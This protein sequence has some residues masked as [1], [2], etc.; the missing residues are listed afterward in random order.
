MAIVGNLY[1]LEK[2]FENVRL[3]PVFDYLK[4]ATDMSSSVYKKLFS[5]P[6]G[7]FEKHI[8]DD[9]IISF[10]QVDYTKELSKCFIESHR[11]YVDFQL[12]VVGSEE[13]GYID[14]DNLTI[15]KPYDVDADLIVYN[16]KNQFSR[17][18]M[19]SESLAIFFPEDGHIGLARYQENTLIRKVVLKV[20][21]DFFKYS[22]NINK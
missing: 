1:K 16:M 13:M 6:V 3:N 19:E 8:L 12:L 22:D 21:I 11:R 5:L 2:H 20:P 9:G 10:L 7:S 15:S 4:L 17:F 14:I 18:V